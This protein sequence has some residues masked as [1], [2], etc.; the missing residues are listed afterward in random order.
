LSS[1]SLLS[2]Q[3]AAPVIVEIVLG[4]KCA[5]DPHKFGTILEAFQRFAD[6]ADPGSTYIIP[7]LPTPSRI[8]C[9][10]SARNVHTLVQD[11]LRERRHNEKGEDDLLQ[12]LIDDEVDDAMCAKVYYDLRFSLECGYC[13]PQKSSSVLSFSL[14]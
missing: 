14:R 9:M 12:R 13:S 6:A 5:A 4:R 1:N 8:R 10:S 3:L 11:L 7:F 2:T